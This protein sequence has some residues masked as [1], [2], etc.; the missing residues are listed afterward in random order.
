VKALCEE[1]TNPKVY[2]VGKTNV[3]YYVLGRSR[4]GNLIGVKTEGVET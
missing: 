4:A 1:L 3:T 2:R